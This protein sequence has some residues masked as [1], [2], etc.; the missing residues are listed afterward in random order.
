[1]RL[2]VRCIAA[3]LA[4]LFGAALVAQEKPAPAVG[5]QYQATSQ[6]PE[7]KT[8]TRIQSPVRTTESAPP[9]TA[10]R[11]SAVSWSNVMV[12]A[13]EVRWCRIHEHSNVDAVGR[14]LC[15]FHEPSPR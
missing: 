6:Q 14:R 1:M 11:V 2:P 9:M 15:T 3:G 4:F 13:L 7:V 10:G 8:I 12:P 5:G